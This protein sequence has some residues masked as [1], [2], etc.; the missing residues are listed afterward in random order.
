METFS[1]LSRVRLAKSGPGGSQNREEKGKPGA[2]K[3]TCVIERLGS[4]SESAVRHRSSFSICVFTDSACQASS[5]VTAVDD[6]SGFSQSCFLNKPVSDWLRPHLNHCLYFN[7]PDLLR[8]ALHHGFWRKMKRNWLVG[9]EAGGGSWCWNIKH[10]VVDAPCAVFL[11]RCWRLKNA[12]VKDEDRG[13]AS[14][15]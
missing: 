13:E 3:N 10:L 6:C 15:S 14:N 11:Y 7:Q 1:G 9:A 12:W 4:R 8:E 5:K 2:C